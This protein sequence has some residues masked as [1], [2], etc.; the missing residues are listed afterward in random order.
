VHFLVGN[1]AALPRKT[2]SRTTFSHQGSSAIIQDPWLS[3]PTFQQVWLCLLSVKSKLNFFNFATP[4][5]KKQAHKVVL[6][7]YIW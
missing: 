1:K 5:G 2:K 4:P 6:T 7:V 3:V